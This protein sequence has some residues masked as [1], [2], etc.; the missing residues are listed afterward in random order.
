MDLT[1]IEKP[2]GAD[3]DC[4]VYTAHSG[5]DLHSLAT[6]HSNVMWD[7]FGCDNDRSGDISDVYAPHTTHVLTMIEG[8][9]VA[10]VE[11][12]AYS[13]LGLP[14]NSWAEVGGMLRGNGRI[15]QCR[16]PVVRDGFRNKPLP[17]LPFG[18]IGSLVKGCL[19]WSVLNDIHHVVVDVV[20]RDAAQ[21]LGRIGFVPVIGTELS[22][23]GQTLELR[24]SELVSRSFR[25][26]NPYFRYL[27]EFD[28]SVQVE[29]PRRPSVTL[30]TFETC[31]RGTTQCPS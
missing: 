13:A 21:F 18:A 20:D 6:L 5:L 22:A 7:Q 8:E 11:L 31:S 28:E 3:R 25:S 10:G 26:T 9:V 12:V 19:Q 17:E 4:F 30:S 15:V 2:K 27:M 23:G 1:F 16:R 29:I 24:V 14:I